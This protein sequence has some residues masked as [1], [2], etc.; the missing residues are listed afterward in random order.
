MELLSRVSTLRLVRFNCLSFRNDNS[1]Q[2]HEEAAPTE[3][4]VF[5]TVSTHKIKCFLVVEA[6]VW[7]AP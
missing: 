2:A 5:R 4:M 7:V 6:K 3:I 1:F